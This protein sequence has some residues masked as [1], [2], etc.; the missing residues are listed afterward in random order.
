MRCDMRRCGEDSS[1]NDQESRKSSKESLSERPCDT[2]KTEGE[3]RR[4]HEGSVGRAT[5]GEF[6]PTDQS[7]SSIGGVASLGAYVIPNVSTV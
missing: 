1:A 7:Q 6:V 3:R 4:K 5:L 2:E